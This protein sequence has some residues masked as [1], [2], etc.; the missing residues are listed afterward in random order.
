MY[1]SLYSMVMARHKNPR[2]RT[3]ITAAAVFLI[4]VAVCR[5]VAT[6]RATSVAWDEP[7]H[8][9]AGLE[10]VAKHTYTLDPIHPPLSRT[11]I[12]LPLYL[13]GERFPSFS[14]AALRKHDYYEVGTKIL[15]DS[16]HY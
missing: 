12:G 3:I 1:R 11:A 9:A 6:Y 5:I 4:L 15:Y 14:D 16:G 7:C 10:W 13:A 8:I 2:H